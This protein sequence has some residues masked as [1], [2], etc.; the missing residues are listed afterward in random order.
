MR[1]IKFDLLNQTSQRVGD[2]FKRNLIIQGGVLAADGNI[3]TADF[4]GQILKIDLI[5]N[6]CTLI[7]RETSNRNS[8]GWGLPV[9]GADKYLYF[10]PHDHDQVLQFNSSTQNISLVS[11]SYTEEMW[12]GG[13]LASNGYI[14]YLPARGNHVLRVDARSINEKVLELVQSTNERL[15]ER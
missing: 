4:S 9:L 12:F 10:P 6:C 5:N 7:E 11:D 3:Y 2:N 8:I 14:Y 1:V 13:A 15:T